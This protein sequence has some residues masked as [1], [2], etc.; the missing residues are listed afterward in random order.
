MKKRY[1]KNSV[2]LTI[3][4]CAIGC[5]G[6]ISARALPFQYAPQVTNVA[7]SSDSNNEKDSDDSSGGYVSN[8]ED[9]TRGGAKNL[10][11]HVVPGQVLQVAV[12][13]AGDKEIDEEARRVS[14]RGE[15]SLPLLGNV[16]IAGMTLHV[17]ASHLTEMYSEYLVDPQVVIQ[18]AKDETSN[19]VTPWGYVTVLG[20]VESP[21]KVNMPPTMDLTVS[22]A[23]Q[24]AGGFAPSA[25]DT[26]IRITRPN[27]DGGNTQFDVNLRRVGAKGELD[28]DP[29]LQP[30]DI[31][32]VPEMI[33]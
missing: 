12:L 31:V 13:V 28:N 10:Q 23:I 17:L 18:F 6:A 4:A 11:P 27:S 14:S 30:G 19:T 26:A 3:I 15:I 25:K 29:R 33:F 20:T 9:V 16:Q 24:Q 22:M 8:N 7:S 32:Y 1:F 5:I 2:L 21:G